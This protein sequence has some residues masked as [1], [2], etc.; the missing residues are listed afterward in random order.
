MIRDE[1]TTQGCTVQL[2]QLNLNEQVK[3]HQNI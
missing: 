2:T 1:V 3:M